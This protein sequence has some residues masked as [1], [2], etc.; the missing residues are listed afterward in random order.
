MCT[1]LTFQTKEHYF[2]RNFDL[3]FSYNEAVT[4]T[5]RNFPLI[6][7]KARTLKRHYAIVGIAR[8]ENNYP[9]YYDGTNEEGLS[10][11]G[12]QFPDDADYREAASGKDNVSSFELIQWILGQC[13][14]IA[15]AEELLEQINP[16]TINLDSELPLMPLHWLIS[17]RERSITVEWLK[18]ETKIYENTVGVLTNNPAFDAQMFNLNNYM[19]VSAYPPANN[20]SNK[21]DLTCYSSGMGAMGMPGDFSSM[22]RFVRAVFVKMNSVCGVSEG[23]SVSQFFHILGSVYM[24]KGCVHLEDGMCANTVYSSCCNTDRGIYYYTTYENGQVTG[25]DMHRENLD[26]MSLVSYPLIA[27][28]QIRMLN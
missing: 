7:R 4:V 16:V 22:S 13:Q 27:A 2:G 21:V 23:E 19:S 8:I 18:G 9:I 6:F 10:M 5:P 1:A 17:D 12:L 25:V 3:S 14:S 15:Q 20:F 11:A 26:G 28:Q 24:P